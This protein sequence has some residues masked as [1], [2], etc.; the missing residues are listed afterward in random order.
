M[1]TYCCRKYKKKKKKKRKKE[2][3]KGMT[4][5]GNQ[6]TTWLQEGDLNSAPESLGGSLPCQS[7]AMTIHT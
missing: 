1:P 2:K 4:T 5:T 6:W 3:E 7:H